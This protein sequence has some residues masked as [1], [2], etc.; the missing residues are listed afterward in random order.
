MNIINLSVI[1]NSGW[2][3]LG[4]L[5]YLFL[6]GPFPCY[7]ICNV[8]E[9]VAT[10]TESLQEGVPFS[11]DLLGSCANKSALLEGQNCTLALALA[12]AEGFEPSSSS[13][14]EEVLSCGAQ[15]NLSG[16]SLTCEGS[17]YKCQSGYSEENVIAKAGCTCWDSS[18]SC[19]DWCA[20]TF[21][22][23]SDSLIGEFS[24]V[25]QLTSTDNV[26]RGFSFYSSS[27][28]VLPASLGVGGGNNSQGSW[29]V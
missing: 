3:W 22:F 19:L 25:A 18:V 28:L 29:R 7:S 8:T 15:G 16:G 13:V 20:N 9:F 6:V 11:D 10:F 21:S 5:A 4:F 14:G 2:S 1:M 12:C 24:G 27:T 17:L 23:A 26:K